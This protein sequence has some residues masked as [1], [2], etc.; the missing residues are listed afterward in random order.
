M[1]DEDCY[2]N[3]TQ[4]V[5][6]MMDLVAAAVNHRKDSWPS[7][8][9][10]LAYFLKRYPTDA[11]DPRVVR[12]YAVRG[13]PSTLDSPFLLIICSGAWPPRSD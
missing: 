8:E 5:Q 6:G 13:N 12:L 11:W 7:K 3:N 1:M 9:A 10:A 4:E 2:L